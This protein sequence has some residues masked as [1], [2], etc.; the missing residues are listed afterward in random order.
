MTHCYYYLSENGY[1]FVKW[2]VG[3]VD[4]AKYST[5]DIRKFRNEVAETLQIPPQFVLIAGFE[6]A[7]SV[8][9]T[10]MIPEKYVDLLEKKL[11]QG[12]SFPNLSCLGVD[13]VQI[14][15]KTFHLPG[16]LLTPY[17]YV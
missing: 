14:R 12:D 7:N 6:P 17:S 10:C 4:P 8:F 15:G 2:H 16:K 9:I 5:Q 3:G 11:N 13:Y 1:R